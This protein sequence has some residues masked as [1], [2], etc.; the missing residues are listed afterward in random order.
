MKK[1]LKRVM[2]CVLGTVLLAGSI[3]VNRPAM[4][5]AGD[6]LSRVYDESFYLYY[7][8]DVAAAAQA[9]GRVSDFARCHFL[10]YGMKEGRQATPGFNVYSYA[11]RYPDLAA[12]FGGDL[13]KYYIHYMA[14]GADEGRD[15]TGEDTAEALPVPANP[16]DAQKAGHQMIGCLTDLLRAEEEA[17]AAAQEAARQE[18]ARKA[19]EAEKAARAEAMAPTANA[20]SSKTD[21]VVVVD[22]GANYVGVFAGPYG[23]R[24]AVRVMQCDTGANGATPAGRYT[25]GVRGTHFSKNNYTCYYYTAFK[26]SKYLFH[27]VLYK[28]GTDEVLDGR[29]GESISHGCVRLSIEDA[30]WIYDNVP[31][32]TRVV[33]Y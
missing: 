29:L 8:P 19:E 12:A 25:I 16:V 6:D 32:G 20:A 10:A 21:Y 22:R 33:I 28:R 26:G 2:A 27:S 31:R 14:F 17:Q 13:E 15:A 24:Q 11:S 1:F 3:A 5:V 9:Y 7:N 30:K 4:A 18:E 23:G